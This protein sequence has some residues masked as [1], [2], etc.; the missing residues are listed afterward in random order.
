MCLSE[1]VWIITFDKSISTLSF[2]KAA[3]DLQTHPHDSPGFEYIV[4]LIGYIIAK[5]VCKIIF[6]NTGLHLSSVSQSSFT[7]FFLL[8]LSSLLGLK[9]PQ[10]DRSAERQRETFLHHG[11]IW[12]RQPPHP[13][14][15]LYRPGPGLLPALLYGLQDPTLTGKP[16]HPGAQTVD[17]DIVFFSALLLHRRRLFI[18]Q[19]SG[20]TGSRQ[21]TFRWIV[22]TDQ[23]GLL[24]S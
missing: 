13:L 22:W 9:L 7:F 18:L 1:S 19:Q 12:Q 15:R 17:S 10:C 2:K 23:Q 14:L 3:A 6:W 11:P 16:D 5:T 20:K 24:A 8:L 21:K 4:R